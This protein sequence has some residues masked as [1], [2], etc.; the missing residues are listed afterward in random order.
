METSPNFTP[1]CQRIIADS[2][3]LAESLFHEEVNCGHLL[4]SIFSSDCSFLNDLVRGFNLKV[5]DFI[6]FVEGFYLFEEA[7]VDGS[8]AYFGEDI[9]EL[10]TKSH[11]FAKKIQNSYVGPEHLFFSFLNDSNGVCSH[12]F[13]AHNVSPSKILEA[14]LV[15]FDEQQA[16]SNEPTKRSDEEQQVPASQRKP[17]AD[18]NSMLESFC[19]NLNELNH[20]G[21]IGKIIGK[22][23]EMDRACEILVKL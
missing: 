21:S 8:E 10:L 6:E 5:S 22:D 13:Y 16:F 3:N 19:T 17:Q 2:K 14:F 20:K 4:V 15:L 23:A 11:E 9:K 1:K 12:F 7:V 18:P